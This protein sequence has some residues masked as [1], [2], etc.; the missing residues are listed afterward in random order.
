MTRVANEPLNLKTIGATTGLDVA[1][2]GFAEALQS[3]RPTSRDDVPPKGQHRTGHGNPLQAS[4]TSADKVGSGDPAGQIE[5]P[6]RSPA[7]GGSAPDKARGELAAILAGRSDLPGARSGQNQQTPTDRLPQ[8]TGERPKPTKLDQGA[9]SELQTMTS[10]PQFAANGPR[11]GTQGPAAENGPDVDPSAAS[12]ATP[13]EAIQPA[14]VPASRTPS[15][16]R[17]ATG[18]DALA[19]SSSP[20]TRRTMRAAGNPFE[21][22]RMPDGMRASAGSEGP[23]HGRA[24]SETTR[25]PAPALPD[26]AE[27]AL[28]RALNDGSEMDAAPIRQ[29]TR[30]GVGG[31][32]MEFVAARDDG[33]RHTVTRRETHFAPTMNAIT[34][35][36]DLPKA[37]P[38][39]S[40]PVA[41][42][43][44]PSTKTGTQ[45]HA[46]TAQLAEALDR[47]L[48][49]V[50]QAIETLRP[51][52]AAQAQAALRQ[53]SGPV[54]LIELQ[55]QPAALGTVTVTMRLS[56]LGLKVTVAAST[57]ETATRL[58]E[59]HAELADLIRKIGYEDADVIVVEAAGPSPDS[60][61][62]SG[63][64]REDQ[65]QRQ[66]RRAGDPIL[67]TEPDRHGRRSLQV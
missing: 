4:P 34:V 19:P 50:R 5:G 51:S 31:R 58:N 18:A 23:E 28:V 65:R 21:R 29:P 56:S 8:S 24:S 6:E 26:E 62:G 1:A 57:R 46:A 55:L 54:R 59:D 2:P 49:E 40:D 64:S 10:T 43:D 61:A 20:D 30:G 33:P 13:V 12:Q 41:T 35:E 37:A 52:A 11:G 25:I 42:M 63:P 44:D 60:D 38:S 36:P 45:P 32:S 22:T 39:P 3:L 27:H 17:D 66:A 67:E 48:P 14:A 16:R 15:V 9:Q 47:A 53:Q 7:T